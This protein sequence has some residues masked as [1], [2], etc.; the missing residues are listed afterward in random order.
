MR[1]GFER[2]SYFVREE[3]KADILEGHMYLLLGRNR[4]RAKVLLFDK[5]GLVLL[6]KRIEDG[7]MMNLDKLNS[8][9][10]I[11]IDDLSLILA[12]AKIKIKSSETVDKSKQ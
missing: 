4:K 1:C 12:G 2:L 8:I 9:N 6:S 10:E 5:T 7:T 3:L 11:S